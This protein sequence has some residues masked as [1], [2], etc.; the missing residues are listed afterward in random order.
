MRSFSR[1]DTPKGLSLFKRLGDQMLSH[2]R[3]GMNPQ[4]I[5]ESTIHIGYYKEESSAV[6]I[7]LNNL[8]NDLQKITDGEVRLIALCPEDCTDGMD[9]LAATKNVRKLN[10]CASS[11]KEAEILDRWEGYVIKECGGTLYI[12]GA[13]PR[14]TIYGLYEMSAYF[15]VSP[16][17]FFADV[18]V[19]KKA[20]I[21]IP[22]GFSRADYPSVQY[23]G[24][25]L[26]D[27]E[28]LEEWAVRHT[29]DGT[30]GPELYEK[31]YELILRLKGNYLWPAMHVNYFQ[32]NPKNSW[33]ANEM[34]I[35]IGTTHCDML[36]RSNQNEWTPWLDK[37]GYKSDYD[38]VHA[39]KLKTSDDKERETIYYDYSIP[40]RNR[41]VIREYW[42]ESVEMNKDY[43]VC[44]TVGMRGVHDY[45]FSTKNIDEDAALTEEEKLSAKI[46]LL[47][48]I[49]EDQ[50]QIIQT[51]CGLSSPSCALQSFIPYKEVLALYNGGLTVPDDVT[52]IW[53]NDNFGHIRR[54]PDAKERKRSGGHGLYFHASYWG[55]TDMSYL[56]FNTMPLAHTTNELRKAYANGIRKIWILNVGALKPLEMDMEVFLA[57]AWDAGKDTSV[58]CDIHTY[59]AQWFDSYFSGGY[60]G[61]L[62]DLYEEYTHLTNARKIEHMQPMVLWQ[63]GYGDEAGARLYRLEKVFARANEIY[64]CLPDPEKNAFFQMFLFKVHSSYYVNHAFYYAD[65][66]VLSYE[67]GN[68]MAADLYTNA[69]RKMT[70]YL[71]KMLRYYNVGMLN[72]KWEGILTPDSFPPPGICLY[73]TC[74]PSIRRRNLPVKAVL[75]DG[76]ETSKG[77]SIVFYRRGKRKKWFEIGNTYTSAVTFAIT[78]KPAWLDLSEES[79]IIHE[80]KRIY[81]RVSND[82]A[83]VGKKAELTVKLIEKEQ[84]IHIKVK[85]CAGCTDEESCLSH[86]ED[87]GAVC[88]YAEDYKEC[89]G[90][91]LYL[92]PLKE[93]GWYKVYG[94]GREGG[95]VVM[96]YNPALCP[97]NDSP[98]RDHPSIVYEFSL[99][100]EG[101]FELEVTRFLTLDSLGRIRFGIGVDGCEPFIMESDT[102]DEWRG[103]WHDSVMNNGEKLYA[104]LPYLS[105]GRHTIHVYM[106]DNYVTLDKLV[107]YTQ[108]RP[109]TYYGA[110]SAHF[111]ADEPRVYWEELDQ[112]RDELYGEND[113]DLLPDMVYADQEF[114]RHN[115]LYMKN[116]IVRQPYMS[117][118]RYD[119]Y[120]KAGTT[121]D[122]RFLF[123]KGVFA[124]KDG[125]I[126]IEAEYALA[127]DANA[128]RTPDATGQI[129]WRHVHALT[130][131]GR[132]LAMQVS[133]KPY[134]WEKANDAPGM[135]FRIHVSEGG[136]YKV[137]LLILYEN[138]MSD[139]CYFA[140]DGHVL[141]QNMQYHN[142][143]LCHFATLHMYFW[144]LT[145][146]IHFSPGEH[147]FS[148]YACDTGL[149]IDRIYLSR[150]EERPPLDQDWTVSDRN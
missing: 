111:R 103:N 149:Q 91:P 117:K 90:A 97:L 78:G 51:E 54:Y 100:S 99:F 49:M 85:A 9:L 17:Y 45:G 123:G 40:G 139:S 25:F 76:S 102:N 67:R 5:L 133:G 65:R 42:R 145:G 144:C 47:E 108:K 60:G 38:A 64:R 130:D 48:T 59:T 120:Y 50:R 15:G 131:G 147:I 69:S 61:E 27:E 105:P 23:R 150:G 83:Y 142:G 19:K 70:R 118:G 73:P 112:I 125:R 71:K 56:F 119:S 86:V 28:E 43:E 136:E 146:K 141:P 138:H 63:A 148:L 32:E 58:T 68:D 37:K 41:E 34:G 132:G 107:I 128:Y 124:E 135:H 57:Y 3:I 1:E 16:W 35:V 79:G 44:Y 30:I 87:D 12:N 72:G 81:L 13:D 82:T 6:K 113:M 7:A 75:W 14:G 80:E 53:V 20:R 77:G 95:S 89:C 29:N 31:I 88:I 11:P 52:L 92:P 33:L 62:A 114:W 126:A 104:N 140:V 129:Y 8:R 26:N 74:R 94:M 84:E 66:S 21:L 93:A 10:Q 137:W 46:K 4:L 143:Q 22:Q 110:V 39:G 106:V 116:D 134:T 101:E 24:I 2:R 122:V 98:L 55:A 36:M 18:P 115:R 127:D 96:A 109:D 121:E